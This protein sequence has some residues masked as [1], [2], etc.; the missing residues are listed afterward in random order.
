[1]CELRVLPVRQIAE[2][3]FPRQNAHKLTYNDEVLWPQ[4]LGAVAW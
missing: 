4:N 3:C 2:C 1:V